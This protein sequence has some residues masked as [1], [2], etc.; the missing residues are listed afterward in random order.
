VIISSGEFS[1][2][3]NPGSKCLKYF[4]VFNMQNCVYVF[5]GF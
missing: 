4:K 1:E 5:F 3:G 2:S